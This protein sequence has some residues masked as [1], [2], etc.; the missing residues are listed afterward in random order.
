MTVRVPGLATN[1]APATRRLGRA[2]VGPLAEICLGQNYSTGISESCDMECINGRPMPNHGQGA[3]RR[4]HLVGRIDVCFQD[5]RYAVHRPA[6]TTC[7]P[8]LIQSCRNLEC[9]RIQLNDGVKSGSITI[10]GLNSLQV[11]LGQLCRAKF[12][13]L[14]QRL[15]CCNVVL[16][17]VVVRDLAGVRHAAGQE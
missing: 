10:D 14:H 13:F 8:F 12:T 6:W 2:E 15:Q 17:V 11:E 5:D 3:R 4:G 1:A 9:L 7:L 16:A